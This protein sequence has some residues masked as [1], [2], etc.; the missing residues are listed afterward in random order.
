MGDQLVLGTAVCASINGASAVAASRGFV[1]LERETT[2]GPEAGHPERRVRGRSCV[3]PHQA[4]RAL[5]GDAETQGSL[6]QLAAAPDLGAIGGRA[7]FSRLRGALGRRPGE[8]TEM[9][10]RAGAGWHGRCQGSPE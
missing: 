10:E 3:C 7:G 6:L 8:G 4:G 5:W 1:K 2:S 9:G